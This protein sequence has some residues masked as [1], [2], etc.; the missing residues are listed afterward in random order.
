MALKHVCSFN[1]SASFT[2]HM[3]LTRFKTLAGQIF[4]AEL[5]VTVIAYL[6]SKKFFFFLKLIF[7]NPKLKRTERM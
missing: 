7:F 2:F 6:Q 3:F 5:G 1:Y 4:H